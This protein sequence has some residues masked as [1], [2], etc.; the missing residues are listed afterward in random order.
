M[1]CLRIMSHKR[2]LKPIYKPAKEEPCIIKWN[3]TSFD[4]LTSFKSKPDLASSSLNDDSNWALSTFSLVTICSNCAWQGRKENH[5][6]FLT[7]LLLVLRYPLPPETNINML[8][9]CF[10]KSKENSTVQK[11]GQ[12]GFMWMETPQFSSTELHINE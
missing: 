5:K 6:I 11:L 7:L 3:L 12:R 1:E 4:S 9:S 2:K 10:K 8:N